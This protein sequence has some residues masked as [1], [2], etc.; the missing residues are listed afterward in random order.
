MSDVLAGPR[1]SVLVPSRNAGRYLGECLDSALG[2]LGPQ[3]EIVVQDCLSTDGSETYLDQ[4]AARDRRVRVIHE[5]D[6]GQSDAL[7]RA[8][9][10]ASGDLVWWL[11]ADDVLLPGGVGAVRA[12]CT[13]EPARDMVVG[14]WQVIDAEGAVL[15]DYPAR[16]L[17]RDRL[18]VRGC[19]AFSGAVVVRRQ[20]LQRVGGYAVDLHYTMDLDLML[21]LL[22]GTG[23][24]ALVHLPLAALRLH[25]D[26][27]SGGKTWS[28][29]REAVIV[30]SRHV[31]GFREHA[32]AVV[33]TGWRLLSLATFPLRFGKTYSRLRWRLASVRER[34]GDAAAERRASPAAGPGSRAG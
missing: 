18:L 21:R 12:A 5:A 30:R 9:A 19:Y 34:S 8:L 27:K 31:R 6:R 4:L 3:D 16:A 29:A 7:N 2:Q 17:D 24:Q 10:R 26:S 33:A 22:G 32:V 13:A 20:A 15:R 25:G 1:I 28:F 23:G 11:N 14:G